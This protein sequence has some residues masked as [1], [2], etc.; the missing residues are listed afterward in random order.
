MQR[1]KSQLML[2]AEAKLGKYLEDGLPE[3][4]QTKTMTEVAR[5]LGLSRSTVYYW[6]L[7]FGAK[8]ATR[9]EPKVVV[10]N[11]GE[12][13]GPE[14]GLTAQVIVRQETPEIQK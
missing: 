7:K 2:S 8:V 12:S 13:S 5:E 11:T 3:L 10:A 6:S 1:R 9:V 4:L 14:G